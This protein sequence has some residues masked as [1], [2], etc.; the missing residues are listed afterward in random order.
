[1]SGMSLAGDGL[2]GWLTSAWKRL[3]ERQVIRE[4]GRQLRVLETLALGPKK[5]LLL[6]R[7]GDDCFLVG[8]GGESVMTIQPVSS[9]VSA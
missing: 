2:A 8:T 9:K 7:C 6:V 5:Q 1:M 4:S 3:R